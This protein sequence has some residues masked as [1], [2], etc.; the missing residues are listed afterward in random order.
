MIAEKKE[1]DART[2]S[3][4]VSHPS[5]RGESRLLGTRRT[6]PRNAPKAA[7]TWRSI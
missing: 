4:A 3:S 1:L 6:K 5:R 2:A 7:E